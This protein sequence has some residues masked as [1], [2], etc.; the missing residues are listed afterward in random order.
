MTEILNRYTKNVI[1]IGDKS[2]YELVIYCLKDGIDL[3]YADLGGADL[4]GVR[5]DIGITKIFQ[6]FV[7]IYK[8][9]AMPI[10]L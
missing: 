5:L 10:I 1:A 8:Y 7:D 2:L 4:R 3:R 6:S 9:E